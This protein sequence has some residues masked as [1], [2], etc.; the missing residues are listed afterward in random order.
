MN[1][2]SLARRLR[3]AASLAMKTA[4]AYLAVLGLLSVRFLVW[5]ALLLG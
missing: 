1:S 3:I 4:T 2:Q 5:L